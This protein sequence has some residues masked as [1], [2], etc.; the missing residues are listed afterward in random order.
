MS[1]LKSSTLTIFS[2]GGARGNPGPSAAGVLIFWNGKEIYR[3]GEFLGV[4]TNNVAEYSALLLGVRKCVEWKK[5]LS[6]FPDGDWGKV[7]SLEFCLDSQ[8]V[9]EQMSGRYRIKD[10]TMKRLS[11]EVFQG[12]LEIALPRHF[13]YIPRAKNA[14][15]DALVNL[16]LDSKL[17]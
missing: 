4:A 5:G 14:E 3:N 10:P 17:Q 16:V 9:V 13:S 8:L 6:T 2:D 7:Q 12:L 1:D 11:D 15:A